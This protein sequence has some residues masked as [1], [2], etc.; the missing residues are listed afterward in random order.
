MSKAKSN[1]GALATIALD[2][3]MST[4]V[5]AIEFTVFKFTFPLAST[6]ILEVWLLAG[7]RAIG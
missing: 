7:D 4:P 1:V 3:I 2:E 6:M 5:D